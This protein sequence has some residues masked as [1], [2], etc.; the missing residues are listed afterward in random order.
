MSTWQENVAPASLSVKANVAL[1]EL[2][3][4]GGFDV[5]VGAGGGVRSISQVYVV[6]GPMFPAASL[7][8]TLNVCEPAL[9][10]PGYVCGSGHGANALPSSEQRKLV[11]AFA[12]EKSK[13]ADV[14]FVGFAG[15]ELIVGAGG[16]VVSIVHVYVVAEPTL[17]AASFASTLN[18][19]EPDE[20]GPGYDCGLAQAAKAELSSEQRN[21]APASPVKAK[22][23]DVPF[24]GFAGEDVIV[25][26]AG[27][28]VSTVHV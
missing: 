1:D 7:A 27:G 16:G 15:F 24:V 17:P 5:I 11:P 14:P 18:V 23:A 22:V 9:S 2:L 28:V 8:S 25:G 26:A 21:V 12:S 3:R 13:V 20:S 4:L 19:C 10:G 6:A